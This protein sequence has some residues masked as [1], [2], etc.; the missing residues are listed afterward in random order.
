MRVRKRLREVATPEDAQFLQRFF[1]SGPGQYGAGDKF[2]G[3]RMSAT[4]GLAREF[5]DLPLDDVVELLHNQWHEARQLAVVLLSNRY[6][7]APE[8]ERRKEG[9]PTWASS[10]RV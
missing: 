7:D 6:A 5:H 3:I 2:L 8:A 1:K 4:R 10:A 9:E